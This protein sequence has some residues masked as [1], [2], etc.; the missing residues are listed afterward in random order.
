MRPLAAF[1]LLSAAFSTAASPAPSRPDSTSAAGLLQ[2]LPLR[3]EP[4]V[5][6]ASAGARFITRSA[7]SR[8]RLGDAGFDIRLPGGPAVAVEWDAPA[9]AGRWA[10]LR[11]LKAISNYFQGPDP[12]G[13]FQHVPNY[14]RVRQAGVFEGVDVE[15]YGSGGRL[16]FDFVA[17][18]GADLSRIVYRVRGADDLRISPS[19]DLVI[20][21]GGLEITHRRPVAY[22][23]IQGERR[24]VEARY[25]LLADQRVSFQLGAFD[26]TRTLVIDPVVEYASY[27]AGD[28]DDGAKGVAVGPDGSAYITGFAEF[29]E[30]NE[31]FPTTPGSFQPQ[32]SGQIIRDSG[33]QGEDDPELDVFILKLSPDGSELV[34]STFLG[35]EDRDV[36][37]SIAIDA[38]GNAYVCGET[39][40]QLF[41]V[42][43]GSFRGVRPGPSAG[44]AAKLS[45]DGSELVYSTFLGGMSRDVAHAVA[46]DSDGS[47]VVVGRSPSAD[48]PLTP[49]SAGR[50]VGRFEAFVLKLLPDGSDVAFSTLLGG[51]ADETAYDVALVDSGA[52]LLAGSSDSSN[53]PTTSGAF[54][55]DLAGG[56][57]AFV[58]RLSSDGST[59]EYATLLG[60]SG[61]D[62]AH[63][64]FALPDGSAAVA[65]STDSADLPVGPDAFAD[66]LAGGDDALIATVSADGSQAT[67]SY[68]GGSGDDE[69][70]GLAVSPE[71]DVL[72]GGVTASAD[73]PLT[74][75]AAQ[76]ALRSPQGDA[77][78]SRISAA[79]ELLAS[80]YYGSSNDD[81][82]H[83]LALGPDGGVY[84]V[85]VSNFEPTPRLP[86]QTTANAIQL[87]GIDDLEAFIVKFAG[88]VVVP[89]FVSVSAAAFTADAPVAPDSLVSGFG[90]DLA[91]S[92]EIAVALPLPTELAGVSLLVVDSAGVERLAEL[93]FVSP[94]QINY[95]VPTGTATGAAEVRV[96][97]DGAVVAQGSLVI[98]TAAP[99]L[100][101]ANADGKGVAAAVVVTAKA[102]GTRLSYNAFSD[103]PPGS[104]TPVPIDLGAEGDVTVLIIFGSGFRGAGTVTA[105]LGEV[106]IPV[107]FAGEQPEFRGLD[108]AN[109]ELNRSLIGTGAANLILIA[110]GIEANP[111]I[112]EIQ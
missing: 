10:P 77:F 104:R 109:L 80:T 6:Q 42:T 46:V 48:F 112:I 29:S 86:L 16:E 2:R 75:D 49:G 36:G 4:N 32:H 53:F 66:S 58:A 52:I 38:E 105:R 78:Y 96:L 23:T 41:P 90:P 7:G 56:A 72:I 51:S 17:R 81:V 67:C 15:F 79:G 97:R 20:E 91:P 39:V 102:D 40:S 35:G 30:D 94:G 25:R 28:D 83:D 98:A 18:P 43:R 71:G 63:A 101:T 84:L 47:A 37:N 88:P 106:S 73:L 54:Q 70:L 85:G 22:Q 14:A 26:P 55:E 34:Y 21:T 24:S 8:I 13:W 9:G 45:P 110:D 82:G 33:E 50:R 59:L 64:L 87:R 62:V 11:K 5:G 68:F 61:D 99:A 19:G 76:A 92:T 57:D 31:Q 74:P 100:F 12:R 107:L 69:A 1:L 60:G 27:F 93:I 65:G 95:I 108:Q 111:A 103:D 3:F 89:A 44:F